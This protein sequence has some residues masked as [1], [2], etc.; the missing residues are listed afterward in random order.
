MLEPSRVSLGG[1]EDHAGCVM[2]PVAAGFRLVFIAAVKAECLK[3][4]MQT[5]GLSFPPRL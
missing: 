4:Q 3:V 5:C 1:E 2:A